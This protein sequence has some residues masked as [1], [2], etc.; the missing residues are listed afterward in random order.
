MKKRPFIQIIFFVFFFA[1]SFLRMYATR[2]PV[3]DSRIIIVKMGIAGESISDDWRAALQTR[4]SKKDIDSMGDIKRKLTTE[5]TEW[6]YLIVSKT[7]EWNSYRDSLAVPF[8]RIILP[9]TIY[10]MLGFLGDDDAFTFEK[11]TVCLDLTAL[12]RVY[13]KAGLEENG[14]RINRIFAHEYT[15]LLHKEWA[16]KAGYNP[17]T[18]LDEILWECLYEGIG[19]YR[20]LNPSWLP[21]N[22]TLPTATQSALRTLYPVFTDRMIAIKKNSSLSDN[23]KQRLHANLSRGTVDKKW[24]AFPVAIWLSLE[25]KGDETHLAKWIDKGPIAVI[26]LAKKYLPA[27]DKDKLSKVF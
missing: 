26:E 25:A 12:S 3:T 10:V 22:D 16:R 27:D 13:G 6:K 24:G 15:H 17:E 11:Q 9:D 5:E 2:H 21:I 8:H 20:S 23:E 4:M 7:A 14:S 19:M 18:F 1:I